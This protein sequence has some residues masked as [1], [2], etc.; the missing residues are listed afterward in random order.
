MPLMN[1]FIFILFLSLSLDDVV[2]SLKNFELHEHLMEMS[3]G[4]CP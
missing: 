1:N 4:A 3:E 2:R